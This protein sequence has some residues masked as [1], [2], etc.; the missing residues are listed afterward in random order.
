MLVQKHIYMDPIPN[1]NNTEVIQYIEQTM[2][3]LLSWKN[4]TI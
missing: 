1:L 4:G 3:G 2:D